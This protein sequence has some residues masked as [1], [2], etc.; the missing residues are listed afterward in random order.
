MF[1]KKLESASEMRSYSFKLKGTQYIYAVFFSE[2]IYAYN[3][4]DRIGASYDVQEE[5]LFCAK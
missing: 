1:D 4:G 3:G 5:N 2:I